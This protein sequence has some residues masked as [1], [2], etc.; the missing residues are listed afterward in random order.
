MRGLEVFSHSVIFRN[1]S[2]G[3]KAETASGKR[4]TSLDS[5]TKKELVMLLKGTGTNTQV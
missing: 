1:L 3:A 5:T 4:V 2:F